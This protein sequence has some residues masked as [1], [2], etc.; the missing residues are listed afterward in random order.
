M[1]HYHVLG[2][3]QS[4]SG[5]EIKKAFRRL[6]LKY[7]P[8]KTSNKEF[9]ELFIT[10]SNAY[11]VLSN[12]TSKAVYDQSN[13]ISKSNF[14]RSTFSNPFTFANSSFK[15]PRTGTSYYD[16]HN[17]FQGRDA[18]NKR[19]E[20][21]RA[22]EKQEKAKREMLD[23]AREQERVRR[24]LLERQRH[25]EEKRRAEFSK[26]LAQ[27]ARKREEERYQERARD[28]DSDDDE[29]YNS[30]NPIVLDDDDE[31][32]QAEQAHEVGEKAADAEE[33]VIAVEDDAD[34]VAEDLELNDVNANDADVSPVKEEHH[35]SPLKAE[36]KTTNT[37]NSPESTETTSTASTTSEPSVHVKEEVESLQEEVHNLEN[38]QYKQNEMKR[39]IANLLNRPRGRRDLPQKSHRNK[40]PSPVRTPRRGSTP[41]TKKM[42]MS[43]DPNDVFT[44]DD[45]AKTMGSTADIETVDFNDMLD[46]LPQERSA[47]ANKTRKVIDDMSQNK[48]P[49]FEY[50]DGTSKAETLHTPLSFVSGH[51]VLEQ[52]TEF[53]KSYTIKAGTTPPSAPNPVLDPNITQEGWTNY[54][55]L[56]EGYRT[57]F[58]EYKK[59]V[60]KY[61]YDRLEKDQLFYDKI[62]ENNSNFEVYQKGLLVDLEVAQ[63]FGELLRVFSNIMS[64]YKQNCNWMKRI[65]S[66]Q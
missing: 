33:E 40:N 13:G 1:S 5:D 62:N 44:F 50:S 21:V 65:N 20:E 46:T 15:F 29:G 35:E 26:K 53:E 55:N 58:F 63:V 57:T 41:T 52:I 23:R 36:A 42:K 66:E 18:S 51:A 9:H 8:D 12:P 64:V 49:K 34:I 16:F 54:V 25:Q 47:K 27:D 45:L 38:N 39:R 11:E 37:T 24:E 19:A 43:D 10:V 3:P 48:R 28:S 32:A 61:Q 59:L 2:L 56:I 60:V 22:R 30:S 6:S 4:A 31:A 17:F 14:S 7:H